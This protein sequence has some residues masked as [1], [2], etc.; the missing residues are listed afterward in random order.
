MQAR[1]ERGRRGAGPMRAE[2]GCW[3]GRRERIQ[4][5]HAGSAW[6][7]HPMASEARVRAAP[8]ACSLAPCRQGSRSGRARSEL[9]LLPGPPSSAGSQT[10]PRRCRRAATA[11]SRRPWGRQHEKGSRVGVVCGAS[12]G[13]PSG[14]HDRVAAHATTSC[15]HAA[16]APTPAA[17]ASDVLALKVVDLEAVVACAA[18]LGRGWEKKGVVGWWERRREAVVA[19]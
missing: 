14:L 15:T 7:G 17:D 8:P 1:G 4:G 5:A 12:H 16:A 13:T 6:R 9:F 2:E 10:A 11:P 3:L 18:S 19:I